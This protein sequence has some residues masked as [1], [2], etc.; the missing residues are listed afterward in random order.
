MAA[1]LPVI[2]SKFG[3]AAKFVEE[4]DGG[5]LVDPQN[6]QE[7]SEAIIKLFGSPDL[8]EQ[9]GNRGR[10]LIMTKYNWENESKKLTELYDRLNFSN[11][12]K[13]N[14]R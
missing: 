12:T 6:E 1:G 4:C 5:I 10:E 8:A 11:G 13:H 2:A 3:E 14:E 7:V 9:M